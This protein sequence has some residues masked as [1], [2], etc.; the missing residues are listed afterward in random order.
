MLFSIIL[1]ALALPPPITITPS[2]NIGFPRLIIIVILQVY[3]LYYRIIFNQAPGNPK[4]K[5][6]WLESPTYSISPSYTFTGS[7]YSL[8]NN[9]SIRSV[10]SSF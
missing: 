1:D 4:D 8:N 2:K 9:L 3:L 5:K 6:S 7:K 10:T